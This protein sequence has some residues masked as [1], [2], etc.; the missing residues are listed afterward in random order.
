MTRF[1]V[2]SEQSSP[3]A[4]PVPAASQTGDN[5]FTIGDVDMMVI[6][7]DID[8]MDSIGGDVDTMVTIA[9]TD[10]MCQ[11]VMRYQCTIN[12]VNT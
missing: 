12:T 8:S 3:D 4:G 10:T 5:M 6:I 11:A 1:V 7:V 2:L 9:D